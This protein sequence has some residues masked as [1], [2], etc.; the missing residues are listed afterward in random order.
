MQDDK[1]TFKVGDIVEWCG[2]RGEVVD[3]SFNVKVKF[4][5][6]FITETSRCD[7][8]T[9]FHTFLDNGK[10]YIWHTEPSLKLIERPKKKNKRIFKE[11]IDKEGPTTQITQ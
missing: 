11:W 6:S 4:K 5:S 2:V 7:N 9:A 8:V 10:E 1:E 3:I